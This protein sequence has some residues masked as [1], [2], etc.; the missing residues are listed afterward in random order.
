M[1]MI[2]NIL[3][4]FSYY[5]GN[6]GYYEKAS[7]KN[8]SREISDFAANKGSANYTYMGKLC[9]INPGAWCA[10]MVSTAVYEACGSDKTAAKQVLWG[11]WP[12]TACNQLFDAGLS[13][14]ASHYSEYQRTKKG[15]SGTAYTPQAGDVIVFSDNG[16]TRSHTGMVYAVDGTTVYTYEG[17]S[18]NM[19]RKR[20]YSL[21]SAYIYG[22]VTLNVEAGTTATDTGGVGAFQ[23]WLGV[24]EDGVYGTK[25]QKAAIA[26]HQRYLNDQM[27]AGLTEDGL[28]GSETYYATQALQVPDDNDDVRI[29]QGILYGRGYDPMGLDGSF[30]ENTRTATEK[31]QTA[32]GLSATGR[33]DA[34]TWAKALGYTRPTHKILKKGSTGSEVRYL[35]RLLGNAGYTLETD[36]S[37]GAATQEAVKAFQTAN[38]LEADGQVGTLTWAAL[39]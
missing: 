20:S 18:G 23:R 25:T 1:A 31:L 30:G 22:Y 9:G 6:G 10:M 4:A 5:I 13:H 36:G 35:Q 17:N 39:E 3:D 24:T 15:K 16:T 37:F 19:A 2:Q 28:W 34:Y 27:Q 12:Y 26:A 33:A 7:A 32:L 11:L 14:D 8:L 21:A 38:G 29:W